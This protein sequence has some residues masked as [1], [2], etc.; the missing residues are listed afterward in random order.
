MSVKLPSDRDAL[1]GVV[2][3]RLATR[4]AGGADEH[5]TVCEAVK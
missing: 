3:Q 1:D 5:V 4:A 2:A